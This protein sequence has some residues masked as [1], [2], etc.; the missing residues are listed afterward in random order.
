MLHQLRRVWS[1]AMYQGGRRS[2]RYFE[3]WYFK[4]VDADARHPFA[5]IPGVRL[6][7]SEEHRYSFVRVVGPDG[8]A[9]SYRYPVGA[10]DFAP[11]APFEISVGP[12]RF[13]PEGMHLDLDGPDGRIAGDVR[14]GEWRPWPVR[15]LSPGA[16][17]SFRFAPR[18]ACYHGVLSLDHALGGALQLDGEELS[19]EGGRGY[20]DKYWGRALPNSRLWAQSNHFYDA[21]GRVRPDTA[22][23]CS[24]TSVPWV[25]GPFVGFTVGFLLDGELH[26]FATHTGAGLR[27]LTMH[28]DGADLVIRD[29]P[30]ELQLQIRGGRA[31][32]PW[33]VSAD[34]AAGR[35]T[36]A[37]GGSVRVLLR[38]RT[39][40]MECVV[41]FEGFAEHAAVGV[42][43][44]E[45]ALAEIPC[46]WEAPGL[47]GPVQV[48][49]WPAT[50]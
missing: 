25:M 20:A 48:P 13:S 43:D 16:M 27:C 36:H 21:Q 9:R 26:R 22:L 42:T 38:E 1:P 39:K 3:G 31:G 29:C 46:R 34:A 2:K 41:R 12:N 44:P 45:G 4:C 33:G 19:F 24:V 6:G 10:F 17:G 7:R 47:L 11:G 49:S 28:P 8:V 37:L 15:T 23:M 50:P 18:M 32:R 5:V 40:D 14:F 35:E 30:F